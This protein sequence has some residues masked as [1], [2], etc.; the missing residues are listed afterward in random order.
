[1]QPPTSGPAF[2]FGGP[3][4][5]QGAEDAGLAAKK[6]AKFD[7]LGYAPNHVLVAFKAGVSNAAKV[8]IGRNYGLTV[9]P[10]GRSPYFVRFLISD[11][12][13]K[14][15]ATVEGTCRR[16]LQDPTVRLAEPDAIIAPDYIPNDPSFSLQFALNNTG[17]TGGTVDADMDA[18]EAWDA[19]PSG[20]TRIVAVCDNGFQLDHPDLVASYHHNSLEIPNNSL[21]DDGNGYVDDYTGW[22]FVTE[23]NNPSPT[24][25]SDDH[26]THCSGITGATCDNSIGIA[27]PGLGRIKVM[28][29]K[30]YDGQSTWV[31]DLIEAIDYAWENGASVISVSYNTDGAIS[32]QLWIEAVQ[33]AGTADVVYCNSAGNNGAQNPP[34]QALVDFASNA[35]FVA[36]TNDTDGLSSFS[37]YGS[38][39]AIAAPG[40]DIYS[41]ITSG[42]YASYSG[43]SMSTP[44]AAACIA[45]IRSC[46]PSLTAPGAILRIV[47]SGDKIPSLNGKVTGGRVNMVNMLDSDSTPPANPSGLTAPKKSVTVLKCA[48]NAVGDDGMTGAASAY[49]FRYSKNPINAGNF[50][51][52]T[53]YLGIIP[54]PASGNLVEFALVG[55]ESQTTYYIAVKAY[56][57]VG[58][59]SGIATAGPYKTCAPLLQDDF[60]GAATFVGQSGQTWALTTS[61]FSSA[62]HSWTDSPAGQYVNSVNSAL[63]S[64]G[65]YSLTTP[66]NFSFRMKTDL[67]SN[68]DYLYFEA[69]TDNGANWATLFRVTGS[70][71]WSTYSTSLAGYTGQ[72]IKIRFRLTSDSSVTQDGVFIDDLQFVAAKT[73]YSDNFEGANFFAADAPWALQN[74]QYSSPTNAWTD[75]PA[76]NYAN[77][78]AVNLKGSNLIDVSSVAAAT[79]TFKVKMQLENNYDYLELTQS[80]D[81]GA[82]YNMVSRWTGTANSVWQALS[83]T[84]SATNQVKIGFRL[85][86]DGSVVYDGVYVDDI[87]IVGEPYQIGLSG[88]LDWDYV[89]PMNLKPITVTV[90]NP[91]TT[92]TETQTITAGTGGTYELCTSLSGNVEVS[93]QTQTHLK[94]TYA[95]NLSSDTVLNVVL[96]NGDINHDNVIDLGDFDLFAAAFGSETGDGNYSFDADLN[97][98]GVCDLGDFDILAGGFGQ[99]GD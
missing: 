45:L 73:I 69:S 68:Y 19:L 32:N 57:N 99:E 61:D 92:E 75:S 12:A 39:V 59:S 55:L 94:K 77:S 14:R 30:M 36:S 5:D 90:Y 44:N 7:K 62:T 95:M 70:N 83:A 21:D 98:D 71:A 56:D 80:T 54:T 31:S 74:A 3:G 87:L 23:D 42:N 64:I 91:N 52:A 84:L 93:F 18:V 16:L 28:P 48:F 67:E 6:Q 82:T 79:V 63:T 76:G 78:I 35:V 9:D 66:T 25:S 22:D 29:L 38:K 1:M 17:Q 49:E 27:S 37:N 47:Q 33:R 15:G 34:R 11:L 60:E 46:F 26:G 43:T 4:A 51:S 10:K 53:R 97:G 85:T 81:N 58:N 41:T 50:N 40:E 89:G 13:L 2:G 72:S 96:I 8:R 86:T 65:S 24:T 20:G 88:S